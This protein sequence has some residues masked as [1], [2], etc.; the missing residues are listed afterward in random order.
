MSTQDLVNYYADLLIKQYVGQPKA[1]AHI[2]TLATGAVIPQVSVQTIAFDLAPTSGAMA[3]D[4]AGDVTSSIAWNDNAA[5]I[6]AALRLVPG[7]GSVTVAGSFASLLLTVTMTGV[8]PV[9]TLLR[10]NTNTLLHTATAVATTVTEIDVTLPLALQDAFNLTGTT[11]VGDQ[12]DI[13][14]KYAGVTRS[15]AGFTTAVLTLADADFLTL[16]LTGIAK[17]SLGSSLSDIIT[18]VM[19][20]DAT[21][22][23]FDH[24]DMRMSYLI[25]SDSGSQDLIQLFVTEGLLPQPMGV[26]IAII[27][28]PVITKFFGFRTYAA[29]AP[30]TTEPLNTY[31]AYVTTWPFLT[32]ATGVSAAA[33]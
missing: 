31:S 13:L 32:Y 2:Q 21:I 10:V 26:A 5:T 23:T 33:A 12:L 4:Y 16:I 25:D 17:N 24:G 22:L 30:S 15:G 7:L 3:L 1:Y 29:A 11:A 27:Y 9:A 6:Q 14:A 28:A 19:A 20:F 8:P 18:F